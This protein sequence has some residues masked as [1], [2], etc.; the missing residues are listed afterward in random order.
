MPFVDV[1]VVVGLGADADASEL[2]VATG[3]LR[4]QLLELDVEDVRLSPSGAGVRQGPKSGTEVA[5]GAL[6]VTLAP[7]VF[8]T[9]LGALQA[10]ADRSKARSVEIRL[11]EESFT[12]SGL[13]RE[14]QDAL[15]A[16]FVARTG[17]QDVPEPGGDGGA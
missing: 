16:H 7:H 11:G 9:V 5:V 15:V 12:G 17:A 6:A 14:Q 3:R 4:R 10:W 8:A 2:F 13:T 1:E